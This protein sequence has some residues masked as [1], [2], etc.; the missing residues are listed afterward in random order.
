MKDLLYKITLLPS[1][2]GEIEI[3]DYDRNIYFELLPQ[4]HGICV[5]SCKSV[6]GGNDISTYKI[7]Y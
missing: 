6:M 3:Q 1:E 7:V 5:V 4:D 2:G